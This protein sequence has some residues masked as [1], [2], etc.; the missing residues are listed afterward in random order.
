MR[1][2]AYTCNGK[3]HY[4]LLLGFRV[5]YTWNR[6]RP[7][8][9]HFSVFPAW[10]LTENKKIWDEHQHCSWWKKTVWYYTRIFIGLWW[11]SLCRHRFSVTFE[12]AVEHRKWKTLLM[13]H[14]RFQ[15]IRVLSFKKC[16]NLKT[17][18]V[19]VILV[20]YLNGNMYHIE[21]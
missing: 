21:Y 1:T 12:N 5:N 3:M 13:E 18:D 14:K 17:I 8:C 15:T 11:W 9:L 6:L 20:K 19:L 7:Q 16:K 4:T 2:I 10:F